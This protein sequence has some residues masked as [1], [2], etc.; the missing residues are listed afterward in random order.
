MTDKPLNQPQPTGFSWWVLWAG[1]TMLLNAPWT[2]KE[3]DNYNE[4]RNR[5]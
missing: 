4:K 3:T 2:R 5:H 1:I